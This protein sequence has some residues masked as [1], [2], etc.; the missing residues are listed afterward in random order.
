MCRGVRAKVVENAY[1]CSMYI[2]VL[3]FMY[4]DKEPA[5]FSYTTMR[6]RSYRAS[7]HPPLQLL[8]QNT[9]RQGQHW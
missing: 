5:T 9:R 2:L 4:H 1:R 7:F 6:Q 3:L 8:D